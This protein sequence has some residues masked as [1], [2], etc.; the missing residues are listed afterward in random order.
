ML[1]YLWHAA[2]YLQ[3]YI[4]GRAPGHMVGLHAQGKGNA[5]GS[6]VNSLG[7]LVASPGSSRAPGSTG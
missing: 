4:G 3:M 6:L 2:A 1:C 7:H 5:I